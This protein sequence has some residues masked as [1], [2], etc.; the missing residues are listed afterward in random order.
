MGKLGLERYESEYLKNNEHTK[1]AAFYWTEEKRIEVDDVPEGYYRYRIRH[2][3]DDLDIPV[4]LEKKVIVNHYHDVLCN[5]EIHYL[6]SDVSNYIPLYEE[7][8]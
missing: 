8:A 7:D 5:M 2:H 6:E 1:D 3:D 4:T